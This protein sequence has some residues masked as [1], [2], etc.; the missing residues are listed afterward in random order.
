MLEEFGLGWKNTVSK[1]LEYLKS[2]LPDL[3]YT[4]IERFKG[5]LRI[6]ASTSSPDNDYIVNSVLYCIERESVKTCENCGKH[7]F[8]RDTQYLPVQKSLCLMC[9]T[10]EID[11]TISQQSHNRG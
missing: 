7:G 11:N 5:M 8:R 2:V 9:Y 4:S 6:K 1:R 3:E 10:I